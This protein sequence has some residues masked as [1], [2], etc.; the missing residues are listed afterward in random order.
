MG[1]IEILCS[2]LDNCES[3]ADVGCDHGYCT[4]Y[5][6]KSG[7]CESAIIADV[8]A[9][10]L[11]KAEK[12]LSAY[13]QSGVCR[14]VCCDGLMDIPQD[15]EQVLIAGMGGEEIIKILSQG[16]IPHKFVLQPMKNAPKLREFLLAHG[17]K[18]TADDI[19]RDDKFYFII[20]GERSGGS[21]AYSPGQLFFG[22]DSLLNPVLKEYAQ[23]ELEKRQRHLVSCTDE[24]ARKKITEEVNLLTEVLK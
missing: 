14:A 2:Y 22:R 3:F 1:R 15:I 16:F 12:L 9:K 20:K 8:S 18:I 5:A 6:L 17:C 11:A 19:F 21:S 4:Q 13:I 24:L 7:K 10:C 23:A